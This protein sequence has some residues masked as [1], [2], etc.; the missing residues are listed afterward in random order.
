MSQ[1]YDT[2][3]TIHSIGQTTEHGVNGFTKREFILLLN[4]EGENPDFPNHMPCEFVKDKCALLDG[5]QVG[6]EVKVTF[7]LG[8]NLWAG[9]DSGERAFATLKAWKIELVRVNQQQAPPQ[10]APQQAPPAQQPPQP[11][12]PPQQAPQA[13]PQAAPVNHE[14]VIADYMRS[15]QVRRDEIWPNYTDEQRKAINAHITKGN[16]SGYDDPPF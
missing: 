12:A 11:Q 9:N 16:Q 3:G 15:G 5:F 13:A 2:Q 7:N 6:N 10:S 14:A 4:G 8:G 1:S